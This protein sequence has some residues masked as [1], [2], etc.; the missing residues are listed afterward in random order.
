MTR[1]SQTIRIS[2]AGAQGVIGSSMMCLLVASGCMNPPEGSLLARHMEKDPRGR[3]QERWDG[4]RGNVTLQLAQQHFKAGRLKD[5]EEALRKVLSSAPESADIYKFAA[6]LYLEMGRLSSAQEMVERAARL[7]GYDAET[8]YLAGMVAERYGRL[9]A[10]LSHF[11]TAQEMNRSVPEYVLA[12]AELYVAGG[13][14]GKALSLLKRRIRDFDGCGALSLLAAKICRMIDRREDA[15]NFC[16]EA[17][18]EHGDD[19]R[20]MC[21]IGE[22]LV[23]TGRFGEAASILRPIVERPVK[24]S[25][26]GSGGQSVSKSTRIALA[27]AYI[28]LDE[29]DK[30][31]ALLSGMMS[32][33]GSDPAIW[34]LF[35]RS[36]L[37]SGDVKTA[38]SAIEQ[39]HRRNTPTADMLLLEAYIAYAGGRYQH[40]A[41]ACDRALALAPDLETARLLRDQIG[42]RAGVDRSDVGPETNEAV[43]IQQ[44]DVTDDTTTVR[45]AAEP[46][47]EP[48]TG[49]DVR[50][51]RPVDSQ[52]DR[53]VSSIVTA[54]RPRSVTSEE[55]YVMPLPIELIIDGFTANR[56][57]SIYRKD[58]IFPALRRAEGLSNPSSDTTK[59][60]IF[61]IPESRVEY[62]DAIVLG[63]GE[64]A[65]VP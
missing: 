38:Q 16:R 24:S 50:T 49:N 45:F 53:G 42:G 64:E 54:N 41:E 5:A 21:E 55:S 13:K 7:P 1:M 22:I 18:H 20:A 6:Q 15:V 63:A 28:G 30:A 39:F 65:L 62:D 47:A 56:P 27:E 29:H 26:R 12:T 60:P 40:A 23:W 61:G 36:A 43:A 14:P 51:Q 25:G 59:T 48:A 35:I 44:A 32:N 4:V 46:R 19:P 17:L 10:A 37:I 2:R 57:G 31:R 8:E 58:S 33:D 3:A 34:S 52:D 9:D 11:K